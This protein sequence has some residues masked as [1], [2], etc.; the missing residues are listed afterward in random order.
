MKKIRRQQLSS[1]V[2]NYMGMTWSCLK[3]AENKW[4]PMYVKGHPYLWRVEITYLYHKTEGDHPG[5]QNPIATPPNPTQPVRPGRSG[6]VRSAGS[7][8]EA[9]PVGRV[10]WGGPFL[11]V[12]LHHRLPHS[13]FRFFP[14]ARRR[15]VVVLGRL[16]F[17]VSFAPAS[18]GLRFNGFPRS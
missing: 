18:P 5:G 7:P 2:N 10:G 1:Y 6:Q 13:H 12:L 17:C 3:E 16:A 14:L 8:G 11:S 4:I 15:F 9:V